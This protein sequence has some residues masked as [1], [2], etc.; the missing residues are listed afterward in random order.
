MKQM[1]SVQQ[2][3]DIRQQFSTVFVTTMKPYSFEQDTRPFADFSEVYSVSGIFLELNDI[4]T[5]IF[6]QED[7]DPEK[8]VLQ[9]V[10]FP[11]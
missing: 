9:I 2:Y 5:Q 3:F 6:H 10:F 1:S 8:Q 11:A 7:S 4:K